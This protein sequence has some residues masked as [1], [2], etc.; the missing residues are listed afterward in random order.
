MEKSLLYELVQDTGFLMQE[1]LR[2]TRHGRPDWAQSSC[3][4]AHLASCILPDSSRVWDQEPDPRIIRLASERPLAEISLALRCL[5][6]QDMAGKRSIAANLTFS[7]RREPLGCTSIGLEFW[8]FI[9]PIVDFSRVSKR[10]AHPLPKGSRSP[11]KS[12]E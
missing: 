5:T 10:V 4:S 6:R 7:R 12:D 8:H 3:G 2:T 1:D 11:A 9:L